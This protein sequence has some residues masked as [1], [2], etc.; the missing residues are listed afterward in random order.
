[1]ARVLLTS[2]WGALRAAGA[3]CIVLIA[4]LLLAFGGFLVSS[5]FSD[6]DCFVYEYSFHL[7]IIWKGLVY[8]H[9][10]LVVRD[11][12]QS[13]LWL[14]RPKLAAMVQW[15]CTLGVFACLARR[16]R[17]HYQ[18]LTA[19]GTVVALAILLSLLVGVVPW[20]RFEADLL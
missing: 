19:A 1:M 13:A 14:S 4:P 7:L 17:F 2:K 6:A 15:G 12:D 16:L 9:D 20:L 3:L 18:L 11:Q 8:P 10:W 5:S